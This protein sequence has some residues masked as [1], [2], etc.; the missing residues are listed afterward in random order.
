MQ[1]E[2]EITKRNERKGGSKDEIEMDED[3]RDCCQF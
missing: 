2:N 3:E 1:T